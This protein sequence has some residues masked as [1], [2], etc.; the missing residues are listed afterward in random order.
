MATARRAGRRLWLDGARRL[1]RALRGPR[2]GEGLHGI[3]ALLETPDKYEGDVRNAALPAPEA[4][5]AT[6]LR[7]PGRVT[8]TVSSTGSFSGS[9]EY[10]GTTYALIGAFDPGTATAN[11]SGAWSF[12][13]TSITS[14][15]HSRG[16]PS[17]P[18]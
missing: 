18:C 5:S 6:D 12:Q 13:A 1:D 7:Y 9:L 3:T 16:R 10:Q 17:G 11:S 4:D 8:L 14:G 2:P 15:T